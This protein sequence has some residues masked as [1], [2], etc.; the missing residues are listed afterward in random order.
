MLGEPTEVPA[1]PHLTVRT[2]VPAD[3]EAVRE[4]LR[5]GFGWEPPEA[6]GV[7]P[8]TLVVER[9]G[10]PIGTARLIREGDRAGVYGFAIHPGHQGRGIGRDVL[11][12]MCRTALAGGAT[13]VSLEVATD[14][15]RALN[16][17]TSLGFRPVI[18]EDYYAL[19]GR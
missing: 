19:P 6:A 17:Y 15:D 12:R 4:I 2:A 1:D 18:T 11:H 10:E 8:N 3:H 5:R 16:L 9:D 13:A 14:N 7:D